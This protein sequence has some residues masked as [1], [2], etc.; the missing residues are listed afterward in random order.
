MKDKLIHAGAPLTLLFL[1]GRLQDL[2]SSCSKL[3][4]ILLF[5]IGYTR[6]SVRK[7]RASCLS[8]KKDCCI[9]Q[10]HHKFKN[11]QMKDRN[12]FMQELLSSFFFLIRKLQKLTSS[13]SNLFEILL[14]LDSYTRL[15]FPKT[16]KF[17]K[18]GMR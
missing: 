4:E 13:C 10:L 15:S 18:F 5:L 3:F 16:R 17:K 2:T 12:W 7:T 6:L 9:L 1:S 8:N 11:Y 14:F